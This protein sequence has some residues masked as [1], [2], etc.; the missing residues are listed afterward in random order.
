MRNY[1]S[2][3]A[4]SQYRTAKLNNI[5]LA[6]SL[7]RQGDNHWYAVMDCATQMLVKLCPVCGKVHADRTTACKH[8]LCP[9]CA[10]RKSR[11]IGAQALAAFEYMRDAG[12]LNGVKLM[13]LTLTQRNVCREDLTG[14]VDKLLEA[15]TRIRKVR[16]VQRFVKGSARNIEI[17]YN[18]EAD[19]FHP[20]V[21]MIVML[22]A[23]APAE[24]AENRFWRDL[25]RGLMGLD[26]EPVCDIRA[27]EDEQGAVCEVSKY[28]IKPGSIFG[29]EL[30]DA[31]FDQ[32]VFF[33]NSALAG[34]RLISYTG[35]WKKAR[36]ALNQ[37]EPDEALD[38]EEAPPIVCGCGAALMD[39]VLR[40]NGLEYVPD[41]AEE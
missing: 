37:L 35:I 12:Q 4:I 10:V 16:N 21:H 22:S 41:M 33:I 20:H 40:W 36:A 15:L 23:D 6:Q 28:C 17:T 2:E 29:I 26:Y 11:R 7:Q 5:R 32:V 30:D 14:E 27:I 31:V 13:L 34:R 24:M 8:R 9:V 19:T 39:A 25:W 18:R 3:S 1:N 38:C